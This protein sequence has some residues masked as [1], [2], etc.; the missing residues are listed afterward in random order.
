M[1]NLFAK[2]LNKEDSSPTKKVYMTQ[3]SILYHTRTE[4]VC[5]SYL[6]DHFEARIHTPL[7]YRGKKRAFFEQLMR[8]SHAVVGVTVEDMYTYPVW[9]DL[10]FAQSISKPFFTL[11][12]ARTGKDLDLLLIEEFT[13]FEKLSWEETKAFYYEI[14]KKEIGFPMLIPKRPEY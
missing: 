4:K 8:E 10:E 6:K 1:A 9:Q 13:D 11:R 7:D 2:L 14:Q 5:K 12:V 3:P